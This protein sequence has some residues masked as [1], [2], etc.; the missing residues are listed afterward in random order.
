MDAIG[1]VISGGLYVSLSNIMMSRT[2][3]MATSEDTPET[4]APK[5]RY[6]DPILLW[7]VYGSYYK[8]I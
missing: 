5:Q 7:I 2:E 1:I 6:G 3:N 8:L 4:P